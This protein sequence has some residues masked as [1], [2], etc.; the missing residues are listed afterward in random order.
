MGVQDAPGVKNDMIL[1]NWP[2]N[3][4]LNFYQKADKFQSKFIYETYLK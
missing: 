3:M 2:R 1:E 4:F